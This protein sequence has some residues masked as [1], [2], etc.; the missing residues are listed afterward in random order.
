[1]KTWMM[2]V[3]ATLAMTMSV[4]AA[5]DAKVTLTGVHLC[6]SGCTKGV[7]A[8]VQKADGAKVACDKDAGS[9]T[10]SGS[11]ASVQKALDELAAAGFHGKSDNADLQIKDDSGAADKK[12]SDLKVTGAH[13]C[14]GKCV[15]G[16]NSALKDV[17]GVE[18]TDAEK[19]AE[20]FTI[21]G[22]FNAAAAIKALNAAGYHV[23]VA[24]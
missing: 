13:L 17:D 23:K 15:K 22:S 8:A 21:K 19:N 3:V 12:V 14:C 4:L 11:K 24:G 18:G 7:A 2:V 6:C 1:M 9:V 5:S 16:V 20:S 10:I